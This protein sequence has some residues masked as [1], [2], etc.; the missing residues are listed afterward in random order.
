MI[1]LPDEYYR[2]APAEQA[3]QLARFRMTHPYCT[4]EHGGGHTWEYIVSG[5]GAETL[6]LLPGGI[7]SAEMWWPL[8]NHFE[9]RYRVIAVS[10]PLVEQMGPIVEALEAI[11]AAENVLQTHVIGTSLGGMVA[12]CLVHRYPDV[13]DRLI[14]SN[15]IAP[16]P[17]YARGLRRGLG[18]INA[19]PTWFVRRSLRANV[20]RMRGAPRDQQRLRRAYLSER[21]A[22]APVK[23]E[24]ASVY[25]CTIDYC[26]NYRFTP[27]DLTGWGG[28][29]FIIESRDDESFSRG[30]RARLRAL[31]P[32]APVHTFQKAGHTPAY[33]QPDDYAAVLEQFLTR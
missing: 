19:L 4:L 20:L 25:R 15:T 28:R 31:Y 14:L 16:E 24:V 27:G 8:I 26:A 10:Y 3:Q 1:D 30:Q 33:S 18:I 22:D 23:A 12:Q 6:L 9:D 5:T 7:R 32:E 13:I 21:F 2:G 29:V 11:L 17:A